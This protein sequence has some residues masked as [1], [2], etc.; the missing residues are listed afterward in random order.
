MIAPLI[1]TPVIFFTPGIIIFFLKKFT[2]RL[3][4]PEKIPLAA[5]VSL[6]YWIIGFWWFSIIPIQ[7]TVFIAA[8]LGLTL[9]TIIYLYYQG[10]RTQQRKTPSLLQNSVD[11]LFIALLLIPQLL[12]MTQQTTPSGRDMSMH[13]YIA[14]IIAYAN[15]FPSALAPLVP[16][17]DFGLYPFGFSTITAIMTMLNTM[18][19]Y[20]NALI[21]SGMTHFLFDYSLYLILRSRFPVIISIIVSVIVAWSS[22]N[23]H[24]FIAWGANPSVLSLTLLFFAVALYLHNNG[25]HAWL[26]TLLLYASLLTNYMF[27][28]AAAYIIIPLVFFAS[29][30]NPTIRNKL[31]SY[32][33]IFFLFILTALPFLYKI[34]RSNWQLP[35]TTMQY[36]QTLHREET[37]A[38]MGTFSG[39]GLMEI[40]GILG[41]IMDTPLLV[42]SLAAGLYL[43]HTHRV[44][45]LV[46]LYVTGAICFFVINARHWWLPLS[47]VLYPYRISLFLLIPAAWCI[48]LLLSEARK[49]SLTV[50]MLCILVIL[51]VFLPRLRGSLYLSEAKNNEGVSQTSMRA[52]TWLAAHTDIHDVIWNRYDDAGLWIPGVIFRPITVYHT[53]PID[54][55]MLSSARKRYPTYAFRR[56]TPSPGIA[57]Q[58]DVAT[59]FP[60]AVNWKFDVV[61]EDGISRI[62]AITR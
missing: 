40:S 3:S 61:Y 27:V 52:L 2:P 55:D 53:N 38:W 60:E 16:I 50:F 17:N 11:I 23:P 44:L 46:F 34:I 7:L 14:A 41:V 13:T 20:T 54:M 51:S 56:E 33:G 12:M 29:L 18:P 62:Y 39:K 24:L 26:T 35:D 49:R 22:A 5:G 4:A 45:M 31:A 1:L 6:T 32:S 48:A 37:A 30:R 42:L 43:F 9:G 28:V 10:L 19:V 58:T 25:K 47:S 21:L 59:R 57:I 36:I 15:G 8:T